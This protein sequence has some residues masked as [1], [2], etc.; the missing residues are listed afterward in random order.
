MM[1]FGHM[2]KEKKKVSHISYLEQ[3]LS[4]KKQVVQRHLS[5]HGCHNPGMVYANVAKTR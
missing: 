5:E 4:R 3:D 1:I 2:P